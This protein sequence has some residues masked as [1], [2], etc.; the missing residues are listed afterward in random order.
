MIPATRIL[1]ARAALVMG[2]DSNQS[3]FTDALCAQTDPEVFFPDKGGTTREAK[4]ICAQCEVTDACL[5]YALA[6]EQ[7]FGVWGGYSARERRNLGQLGLVKGRR[8]P[9]RLAG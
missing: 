1:L 5:R 2:E 6:T 7:E 4:Q 9:G 3:F 8:D